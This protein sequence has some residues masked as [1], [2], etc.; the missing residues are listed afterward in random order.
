MDRSP[1]SKG[2]TPVS[3]H[4]ECAAATKADFEEAAI[5]SVLFA[6]HFFSGGKMVF[7]SFFILI[8]IHPFLLASAM[9]ASE[10]VPTW[11]SGRPPPGP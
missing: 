4:G 9:R 6:A 2:L 7:Q 5:A 3:E 8:T 1:I 10:K 11:V